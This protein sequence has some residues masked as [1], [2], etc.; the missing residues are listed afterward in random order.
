MDIIGGLLAEAAFFAWKQVCV[1][2]VGIVLGAFFV[3]EI[4]WIGN[5]NYYVDE[6]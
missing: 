4:L 5:V 2:C 1:N 6:L 3:A